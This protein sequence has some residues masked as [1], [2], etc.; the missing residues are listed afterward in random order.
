M[1]KQHIAFAQRREDAPRRLAVGE[2]GMGGGNECRIFERRPVDAVDLPQRRQV[3]QAGHFDDVTGVH[4]E[5]A[6]QQFQHALGHV[7]GDLESHRRAEPPARQ[8]PFQRLQQVFVAVLFDLVVGVAGDAEG[9]MLNDFHAREKHRAGR[10]RSALPS[11]DSGR[12]RALRRLQPSAFRVRRS[13]RRCSGTLT[14]AKC[15]PPSSGWRTV[16]ARFRLSP[17]TNGNGWAGSTASGVRTGK[18]CSVK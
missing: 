6:Q 1:M 4:V 8:F 15:W 16:T 5:F 10:P 12:F 3:E 9:V 14:R 2:G 17:L 18:T 7:V 13:D 11:A